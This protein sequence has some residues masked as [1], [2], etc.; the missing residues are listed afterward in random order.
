MDGRTHGR[1][2]NVKTVYPPQTKFAGAIITCFDLGI[3]KKTFKHTFLS[4]GEVIL[5]YLLVHVTI[6]KGS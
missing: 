1:M 6:I 5:S 4:G 2:D 3:R